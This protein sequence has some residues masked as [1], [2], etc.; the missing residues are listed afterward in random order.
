MAVARGRGPKVA[1]VREVLSID[2]V[3]ARFEGEWVLLEITAVEEGWPSRGRVVAHGKSGPVHKALQQRLQPAGRPD[4]GYYIF[5]ANRRIRTGAE[6]RERL[7]E[8]SRTGDVRAW[9][10]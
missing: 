10:W 7:E 2:E 9:R 6:L 3:V 5:Q 1:P 8:L 4:G